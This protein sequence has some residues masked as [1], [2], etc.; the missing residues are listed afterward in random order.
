[1]PHKRAKRSVRDK[2]QKEQG[3]DLVPAKYSLSNEPI[4][5]S[6]AWVL[7]AEKVRADFRAKKRS[8]EDEGGNA[9]AKRRK[10][11][12]ADAS[13]MIIKPGETLPHFNKR[14]EDS[15]RGV[16]NAAVQTSNT[17][18]RNTAKKEIEDK[19]RAKQQKATAASVEAAKRKEEEKTRAQQAAT[20]KHADRAKEFQQSS[21]SAPRRLND[22]AQAPPDF[23]KLPRGA[24]KNTSAK[25]TPRSEGHFADDEDKDG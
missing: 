4:P 9:K 21:T 23:K 16:V 1:M 14:V 25:K 13:S 7:N 8:A 22:I 10:T 20:D 18:T 6:V 19:K 17:T 15:M 11:G 2:N 12:T 5:K 24:A 3:H